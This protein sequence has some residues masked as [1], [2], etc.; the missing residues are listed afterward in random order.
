MNEHGNAIAP[1]IVDRHGGV[2]QA[3][4]AV[5][6]R[7]QRLAGRLEVAVAHTDAGF[8][9]HAGEEFRH[10][11]LAVVDQR[12][13]DAAIARRRIGRQIFDVERLDDVDHEVRTGRAVL[14]RRGRGL[15]RSGLRGRDMSIGRQCR[16]QALFGLWRSRGRGNRRRGGRNAAGGAGNRCGCEKFAAIEFRSRHRCLPEF[17]LHARHSGPTR[18]HHRR[19]AQSRFYAAKS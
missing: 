4:D 17:F 6:Q 15:R 13:M 14:R 2:L 5:D 19:N 3:D 10:R 16:G 12:F 18:Y 9:V 1:G 11:V 7:H 8:L